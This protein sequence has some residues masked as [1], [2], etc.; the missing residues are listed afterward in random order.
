MVVALGSAEP[1]LS[2]LTAQQPAPARHPSPPQQ[3]SES[4]PSK[5]L[6]KMVCIQ[7]C[8]RFRKPGSL[9]KFR[10]ASTA[11]LDR[12]CRL[13]PCSLKNPTPPTPISTKPWPAI[14]A[15]APP[16]SAFATPSIGLPGRRT[17]EHET[18]PGT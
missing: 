4:S 16:T 1:A 9:N 14:S 13:Q 3:A 18:E 11:N 10:N 5:V 12:S 6:P 8:I 7:Y 15:V 17:R 2:T